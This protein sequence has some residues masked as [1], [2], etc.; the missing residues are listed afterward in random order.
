MT[1]C[2]LLILIIYFYSE[3][4]LLFAQQYPYKHY[5]RHPA[6]ETGYNNETISGNEEDSNMCHLSV[7]CPSIP[8]LCK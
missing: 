5:S 4:H 6:S 3:Q 7:R 8:T 1:N 2:L